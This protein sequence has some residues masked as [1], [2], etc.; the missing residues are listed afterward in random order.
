MTTGSRVVGNVDTPLYIYKYW[1]GDNG[2]L[3]NGVPKWNAYVNYGWNVKQK[4]EDVYGRRWL[5]EL[6]PYCCFPDIITWTNNDELKLLSDLS[7][8]VRG[9]PFNLGVATATGKQTLDL[10]L[11]TVS[12][13]TTSV[14]LVKRGRF[15]DAARALG[16]APK[17]MPPH[18]RLKADNPA[19]L[20]SHDVSSAWLELQYGWLPLLSDVYGAQKAYYE[21]TKAPRRLKVKAARSVSGKFYQPYNLVWSPVYGWRQFS[22]NAS[23]HYTRTYI[24]EMTEIL[25]AP[26]SLGLT[27][28]ASIAWEIIPFS[29]VAD[30][31]IPIG[32]YFDALNTIPHLG[33]RTLVV[34]ANKKQG[35][36]VGNPNAEPNLQCRG[37]ETSGT[38]YYYGRSIPSSISVPLPRFKDVTDALNPA[39]LKNGVALLHQLLH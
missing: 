4:R 27:D 25:S 3:L 14:R 32:T 13:L 10:A 15:S 8:Q 39:H 38:F 11:H 18:L 30:W 23:Q 12:R 33:G 36:C 24:H 35:I 5:W 28:P 17:R 26:R 31:F 20:T 37:S 7:E 6:S 34:T 2:R 21:L 22:T 19:S 9:H 29:F 1:S 16:V